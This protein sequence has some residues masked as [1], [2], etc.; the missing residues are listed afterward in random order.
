MNKSL[1]KYFLPSSIVKNLTLSF[2]L[3]GGLCA[4][5]FAGPEPVPSGKEMK[6]VAPAPCPEFY[7]DNEWNISVWGAY[8]FC[9]N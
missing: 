4:L 6:Q 9:L 5:V 1:T 7:A 3:V 2:V 8:A